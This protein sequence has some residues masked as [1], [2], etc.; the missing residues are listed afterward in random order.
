MQIFHPPRTE[1][2]NLPDKPG[3]YAFYFDLG[4]FLKSKNNDDRFPDKNTDLSKLMNKVTNA[5]QLTDPKKESINIYGIS[6]CVMMNIESSH[7]IDAGL[8]IGDNSEGFAQLVSLCSILSKPLYV[9]KTSKDTLEERFFS[10]R[11]YY[12]KLS[13]EVDTSDN[14]N[15]FTRD[16]EFPDKLIRRNIEFRDL[17]FVCV[18]ITNNRQEEY[19]GEVEKLL[20]SLSNPPLSVKYD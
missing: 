12:S 3:L 7:K 1:E 2:T 19:I 14:K 18:P 4:I 15:P 10:H 17:I 5:L 13:E 9:G 6:K 11:Q 20:H 16:G 8:D